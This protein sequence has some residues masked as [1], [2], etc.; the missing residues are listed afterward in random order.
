M[1]TRPSRILV[2]SELYPPLI[3]GEGVF[4]RNLARGLAGRGHHLLVVTSSMR[5]SY[6]IERDG[7]LEIHRLPSVRNPL[8]PTFRISLPS[9]WLLMGI[10]D[11][12]RPEA[13]QVNNPSWAG[14]RILGWASSQG[15]RSVASHHYHPATLWG[16]HRWLRP[17]SHW[18][19]RCAARSMTG[20]Y[21]Q[22]GVVTAPSR[23]AVGRLGM[24]G[25]RGALPVSN[26]IDLERFRPDLRDPSVFA[27][28]GVPPGA[29]VVLHHGRLY[30]S[31]RVDLILRAFAGMP[32]NVWLVV[33]GDGPDRDRLEGLAPDRTKF[34]GFVDDADLPSLFAS[35]DLFAI[36]SPVELQ[37][38]VVLEAMASG[39]AVV[40]VDAGAL[41]ELVENG[42]NGI[43]CAKDSVEGFHEGL[44]NAL[45]RMPFLRVGAR[46]AALPHDLART[47]DRFEALLRGG[48][49][50]EL[51]R[52]EYNR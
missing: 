20:F 33:S 4:A 28:W 3:C 52:W 24:H 41:P 2:Q 50:G 44:W 13:V 39:L 47:V 31:K 32:E 51:P 40:A 38:I 10:L 19:E 17:F 37:G 35:S 7:E 43:L 21:S 1:P 11:G 27:K 15:A 36:A 45:D 25:L 48:L 34:V 26:G 29:R 49:L 23:Y 22:A 5:G 12:F 42:Q 18:I 16:N 14:G 30:R 46:K 9:K 6:E 8:Y